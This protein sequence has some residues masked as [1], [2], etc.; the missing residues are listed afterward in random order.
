M[1]PQLLCWAAHGAS[2]LNPIA[3]KI[4][5]R[6]M[7]LLLAAMAFQFMFDALKTQKGLL[8]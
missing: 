8:F 4:A 3:M 6:I 5:T 7:G 2:R 1:Q